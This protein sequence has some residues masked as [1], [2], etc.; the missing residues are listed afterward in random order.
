[1]AKTSPDL[2]PEDSPRFLL[3]FKSEISADL[4]A[5]VS[6]EERNSITEHF[7]GTCR[8]RFA[9]VTD[10]AR[11][12]DPFWLQLVRNDLNH[13]YNAH[14]RGNREPADL[15]D[16]VVGEIE[17]G[18][19]AFISRWAERY[20]DNVDE[21]TRI[22]AFSIAVGKGLIKLRAKLSG[23]RTFGSGVPF[24]YYFARSCGWALRDALR[25]TRTPSGKMV[26]TIVD[27]VELP[28]ASDE[29]SVRVA[30]L[31]EARQVPTE[32]S[33][34]AEYLEWRGYLRWLGL[35]C[36][37]KC[38]IRETYF[39]LVTGA[40]RRGVRKPHRGRRLLTDR[41]LRQLL[42]C[43][44]RR[45][46]EKP[47][48]D[49]KFEQ[50]LVAEA[51]QGRLDV[52]PNKVP[53]LL[54]EFDRFCAQRVRSLARP[55]VPDEKKSLW[56]EAASELIEALKARQESSLRMQ[57]YHLIS[58]SMGLTP[59]DVVVLD[60]FK[61]ALSR[62]YKRREFFWESLIKRSREALGSG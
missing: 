56:V 16:E 62:I 20:W 42:E 54:A 2:G 18:L 13:F 21:W 48:K 39:L 53:Q 37:W 47:G 11:R 9:Y 35:F 46:M 57:P 38:P 23:Y 59:L 51:L 60:H 19:S 12:M 17:C 41:L 8:S 36:G 30:K 32:L 7:I 44:E 25:K 40:E 10:A 4:A 28:E 24:G 50:F 6:P 26:L 34:E 49:G 15:P 43:I 29:D 1:M 14:Y 5:L 27:P 31:R 58:A 55:K 33:R 52:A 45:K 22:E 3:A 61:R